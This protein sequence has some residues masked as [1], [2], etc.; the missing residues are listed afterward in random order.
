M[1]EYT[2]RELNTKIHTFLARKIE[3][4]HRPQTPPRPQRDTQSEQSEML[5]MLIVTK[6]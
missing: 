4:L 1:V 2:E 6:N 3:K 5:G